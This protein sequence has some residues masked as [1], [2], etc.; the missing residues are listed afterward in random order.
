MRLHDLQHAQDE[1]G[2]AGV[3]G[4]LSASDHL[5]TEFLLS[6]DRPGQSVSMQDAFSRS[7]LILRELQR[8]NRLS[9]DF[10]GSWRDH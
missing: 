5:K 3:S 8:D 1:A 6:I 9:K 7:R 4:R 2:E 10:P